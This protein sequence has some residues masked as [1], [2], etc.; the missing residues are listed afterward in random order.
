MRGLRDGIRDTTVPVSSSSAYP[1]RTSVTRSRARCTVPERVTY[2]SLTASTRIGLWSSTTSRARRSAITRRSALNAGESRT[3]TRINAAGSSS[4]NACM[5]SRS[6][7][8]TVAV[9][10]SVVRTTVAAMPGVG[11]GRSATETTTTTGSKRRSSQRRDARRRILGGG[12][13]GVIAATRS[14]CTI[15]SSRSMDGC[16]PDAAVDGAQDRRLFV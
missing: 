11:S 8:S 12:S 6:I 5:R 3:S 2:S 4:M 13:S 9:H 7:R 14:S 1:S 10:G 16:S 15:A